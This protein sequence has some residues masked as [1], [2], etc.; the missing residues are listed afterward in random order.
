MQP[1][2]KACARVASASR[3][4]A[5][6][7][8]EPAPEPACAGRRLPHNARQ[9]AVPRE[10]QMAIRRRD[11]LAGAAAL[12]AAPSTPRAQAKPRVTFISQWASGSDGA[13]ITGLGK[14]LEAEGGVWQHSPVPGFTTE[15]MNNL[16]AATFAVNPPASSRLKAPEIAAWC[17][18]PRTAALDPL[19]AAAGYEKLI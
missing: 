3:S 12:A 11:L 2:S 9:Q 15:M 17:K 16:P 4:S 1:T 10:E 18:I 8:A 13:A 14:R 7:S 5:P 19:V 6:T